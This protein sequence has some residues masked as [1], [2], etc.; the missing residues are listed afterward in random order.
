[1]TTFPP[2]PADTASVQQMA[3]WNAAADARMLQLLQQGIPIPH[4]PLRVLIEIRALARAMG[5]KADE[6]EALC[7]IERMTIMEDTIQQME[8]M[9][10]RSRLAVP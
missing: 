7:E 10:T 1:M 9:S 6:W 3:E 2:R 8:Q 5:V 4:N